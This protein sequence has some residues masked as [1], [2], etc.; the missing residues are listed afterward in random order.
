ME[1]GTTS[2]KN[3]RR[4]MDNAGVVVKRGEG[5]GARGEGDVRLS[6]T[7]PNERLEEGVRRLEALRL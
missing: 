1:E 7:I 6:V 5:Y 4:L 3:A 2:E